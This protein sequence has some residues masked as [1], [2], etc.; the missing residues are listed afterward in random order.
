MLCDDGSRGASIC[1][2]RNSGIGFACAVC[3]IT[4]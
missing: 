1:P 4:M 3:P 2:V